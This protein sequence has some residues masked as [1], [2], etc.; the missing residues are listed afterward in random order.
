MRFPFLYFQNS[1]NDPL[2]QPLSPHFRLSCSIGEKKKLT[3]A[4]VIPPSCCVNRRQA[5]DLCK[6]V[7]YSLL[8]GV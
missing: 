8:P 1:Q 2:S 4:K 5:L 7:P 3:M 6:P